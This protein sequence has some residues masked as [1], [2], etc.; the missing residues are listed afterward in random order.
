MVSSVITGST[1][2]KLAL[3]PTGII[4]ATKNHRLAKTCQFGKN[5]TNCEG[6][7]EFQSKSPYNKYFWIRSKYCHRDLNEP[8][9]YC[10]VVA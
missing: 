3:D 9:D 8:A 2:F 6:D 5:E 1:I 10:T 7:M 4:S